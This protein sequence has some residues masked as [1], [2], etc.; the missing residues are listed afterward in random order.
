MISSTVAYPASTVPYTPS[1][2][3]EGVTLQA[4][5]ALIG[6]RGWPDLHSAPF[7]M[8]RGAMAAPQ[9]TALVAMHF[10]GWVLSFPVG[11]LMYC[12]R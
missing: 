8:R 12:V 11:S 9:A 2:E 3:P 4:E 7:D 1:R 5:R 10:M 6:N